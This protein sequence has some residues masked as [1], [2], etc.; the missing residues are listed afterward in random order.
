[1]DSNVSTTELNLTLDSVIESID[2]NNIE[3]L[4]LSN[5][6]SY[7]VYLKKQVELN[8]CTLEQVRS[9][10]VPNL[11]YALGMYYSIKFERRLRQIANRCRV[12]NRYCQKYKS[13]Y[14]NF[15]KAKRFQSKHEA[16]L[17]CFFRTFSSLSGNE[18][19]YVFSER[20]TGNYGRGRELEHAHGDALDVF[21]QP[22]KVVRGRQIG[23]ELLAYQSGIVLAV[24]NN[25]SGRQRTNYNGQGLSPKAGNGLII[26]NPVTNIYQYY[27]HMH[28]VSVVPG[29]IVRAGTVLGLVGNTGGRPNKAVNKHVHF[30]LHRNGLSFDNHT[31]VRLLDEQKQRMNG[32]EL[33]FLSDNND[34][35]HQ[36]DGDDHDHDHDHL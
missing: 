15:I 3:H 27:S 16:V 20:S 6:N 32:I 4:D 23:P 24:G 14:S 33:S 31:L 11:D 30:E 26:Y 22:R 36:G 12:N 9:L 13:L 8:N 34:S 17:N 1:M 28:L 35:D 29:Q 25:W 5:L 21:F 10:V 18:T 19:S 2:Y 7:F